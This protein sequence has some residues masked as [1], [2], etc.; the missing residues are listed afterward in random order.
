MKI[1]RTRDASG[2]IVHL[3]ETGPGE[4][5]LI[6]GDILGDFQVSGKRLPVRERMAPLRPPLIIGIAQN[7]KDHAA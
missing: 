4:G 7:Y 1:L 2:C 3:C 6:E 5:N